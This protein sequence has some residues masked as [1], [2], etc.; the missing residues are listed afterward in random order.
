VK[1]A[2]AA[3][4]AFL[5][6]PSLSPESLS[7]RISAGVRDFLRLPREASVSVQVENASTNPLAGRLDAVR[8]T[9]PRLDLAGLVLPPPGPPAPRGNLRGS[10]GSVAIH[11]PD[12]S[13][14]ALHFRQISIITHDLHYNL[15]KL[16]AQGGF[17]LAEAGPMRVFIVASEADLNLVLRDRVPQF[18]DPRVTISP[19]NQLSLATGIALGPTSIPVRISARLELID[20]QTISLSQVSIALLGVQVPGAVTQ[21]LTQRF[22]TRFSLAAGTPLAKALVL[23]EIHTTEGYLHVSGVIDV[24]ALQ[25]AASAP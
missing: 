23:D 11:L 14:G 21:R 3:L 5:L 17:D 22:P 7:L 16:L 1:P 25:V 4:L 24:A 18:A 13:I 15:G 6:G 19:G 9:I 12:A 2:A 8:I 10:V 20:P